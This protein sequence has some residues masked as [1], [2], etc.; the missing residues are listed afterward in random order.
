M[1]LLPKNYSQFRKKEYWDSFFH[2]M[3]DK[4]PFDWYGTLDN[5]KQPLFMVLNDVY[6]SNNKQKQIKIAHLGCGNSTL[7]QDLLKSYPMFEFEVNNY[8]YSEAVI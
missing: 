3:Q 5:F 7:P 4:R 2:E 6:K 8:D 1:N